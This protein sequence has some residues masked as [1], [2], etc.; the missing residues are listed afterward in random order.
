[1]TFRLEIAFIVRFALLASLL[2]LISCGQNISADDYDRACLVDDDCVGAW[3][4]DACDYC[5]SS[6]S[7]ISVDEAR[8]YFADL[9][10][11]KEGCLIDQSDLSDCLYI[12]AECISGWCDVV[13]E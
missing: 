9:N 6:N 3:T 13:L 8:R 5:G 10:S 12:P 2:T 7:A 4:G 11:L 1:M